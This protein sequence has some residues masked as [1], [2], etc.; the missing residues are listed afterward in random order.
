M[1]TSNIDPEVE[2]TLKTYRGL[3]EQRFG[4]RLLS[5]RLFGSRARGDASP[6]S[7]ADIAVVIRDL[8][9]TERDAA[10][11]MAFEAWRLN[12]GQGPLPAPLVWSDGEL[13]DRQR[14]ERRIALDIDAEGIAV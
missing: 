10:I 12:G 1:A 14:A 7:D 13:L 9:E 2:R 6:D 5:L 4:Q 3:L 8:T 11:R